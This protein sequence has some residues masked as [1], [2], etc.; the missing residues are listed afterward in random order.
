MILRKTTKEILADSMFELAATKAVDKI[1]I[2]EIV[3]NCGL[4][5]ATFYRYFRDK[6]ELIAWIFNYKMET[7]FYEF[8]NG[9]KTWRQEIFEILVILDENKT[10]YR[11]TI[12]NTEGQD[13]FF[14]LLIV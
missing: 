8:A 2:K 6:Y 5:S 7:K 4:S 11:N 12:K 1:T 10:F 9:K 3:E 13:S 14:Y